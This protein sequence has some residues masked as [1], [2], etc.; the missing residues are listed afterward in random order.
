MARKGRVVPGTAPRWS[1]AEL[2]ND[3]HRTKRARCDGASDALVSVQLSMD[4][5]IQISFDPTET[6][7]NLQARLQ[8]THAGAILALGRSFRALLRT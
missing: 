1:D 7:G 2:C 8:L 6:V 3:E 4:K 5:R